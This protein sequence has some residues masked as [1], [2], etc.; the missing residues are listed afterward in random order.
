MKKTISI[1]ATV[2]ALLACAAVAGE[3]DPFADPPSEPPRPER[4]IAKLPKAVTYRHEGQDRQVYVISGIYPSP[5]D[6]EIENL[7]SLYQA[8]IP[9]C[10]SLQ[11]NFST[12]TCTFVTSRS[13]SFSE[14]AYAID[15][16]AKYGGNLPYWAELEARDL[17]VAESIHADRYKIA[18]TMADRLP[19]SPAW[20]S[21]PKHSGFS[22]PLGMGRDIGK[23]LVVPTTAFCMCHSR[24]CIRI[25]DAEGQVIWK[26]ETSAYGSVRVSIADIDDDTMHE[27]FI[28]RHDH[29]KEGVHYM[30]QSNTGAED[31]R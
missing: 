15:D 11:L 7:D 24:Y 13:L 25:L 28:E 19:P 12:N 20:Y 26:D 31:D 3:D 17:P 30:I 1:L 18:K 27:V 14:L 10:T 22:A 21:I 29:G 16:L 9:D 2:T 4:E 23:L 8:L 6:Q 5:K